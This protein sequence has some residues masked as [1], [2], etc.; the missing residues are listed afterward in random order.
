MSFLNSLIAVA[1]AAKT[2]ATSAWASFTP[3]T[4]ESILVVAALLLVLVYVSS[5]FASE[6]NYTSTFQTGHTGFWMDEDASGSGLSITI[7]EAGVLGAAVFTFSP[8]TVPALLPGLQSGDPIEAANTIYL[9]GATVTTSGQYKAVIPLNLPIFGEGFM[10]AGESVEFGE[11]ELTVFTCDRIDYKATINTG[12]PTGQPG[13]VSTIATGTL[14]PLVGGG[15][16]CALDCTSPSF[17]PFPASCP[18]R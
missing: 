15:G 8:T 4:R 9:V 2:R 3:F 7:N 18:A 17:G 6:P 10:G 14:V 5:A 12:F 1:A 13:I 11:L 16:T